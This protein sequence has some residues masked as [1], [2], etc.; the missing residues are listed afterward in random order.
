M[1]VSLF[2]RGMARCCLGQPC[3][4]DDMR[5]AIEMQRSVDPLVL[6]MLIGIAYGK[7]WQAWQWFFS[8]LN[9]N[10]LL[11]VNVVTGVRGNSHQMHLGKV[12]K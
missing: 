9:R 10:A 4:R 5:R 8:A 3:W 2:Y 1:A 6:S 11:A 7:A 12:R